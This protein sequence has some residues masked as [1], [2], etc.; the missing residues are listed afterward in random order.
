MDAMKSQDSADRVLVFELGL[1]EWLNE[2]GE[3]RIV[4]RWSSLTHSVVSEPTLEHGQ[5]IISRAI[6]EEETGQD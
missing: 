4:Y 5:V 3:L 1:T 6:F 2:E